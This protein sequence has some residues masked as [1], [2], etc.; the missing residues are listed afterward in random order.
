MKETSPPLDTLGRLGGKRDWSTADHFRETFTNG[1]FAE[2]FPIVEVHEAWIAMLVRSGV[3]PAARGATILQA[4]GKIDAAAVGEMI[5]S[6]DKRFPKPILQVERYLVD[7]IGM[8]ATD[9]ILE[10][11]LPP[12]LY[13]MKARKALLPLIASTL[14]LME[15][16]LEKSEAHRETVMPG[17]THLQH[18]QPMTFGHYLLG[19]YDALDR[20]LRQLEAA[21]ATT[22]RCDMGCGALAGVSVLVDRPFLAK[23]LGFDGIIEHSNDCVAA[24]DHAVDTV[25][26]M[27]NIALP[28]SRVAN[29][30]D[31]WSGFE[32]DMVEV[33]DE[34]AETSSL[35]PQ[36]KNPCV[37][38]EVRATI[39]VVSG[40]YNEIVC[41]MHNTSYGDT[42]EVQAACERITPTAGELVRILDFFEKAVR[43]L[44]VKAEK[45]RQHASRG[46]STVTELVAILYREAKLPPRVSH[47]IVSAVVRQVVAE[48]GTAL[49][50]RATAINEIA[51]K[52]I[53]QPLTITDD[54]IAAALD[55]VR[56]VEAHDSQGGVAPREVL[57]MVEARKG[58]L[59]AAG[60]RHDDRQARLEAAKLMRAE[61]IA[62]ICDRASTRSAA[63]TGA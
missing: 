7:Q 14:R 34:L 38:E 2:V 56:F 36:K 40:C 58:A 11:T 52:I 20:A 31:M 46:F 61:V 60:K 6:Y 45:M 3:V 13:R 57:R 35:M 49:D 29:E 63:P 25:L 51:R 24:T 55:P 30:L 47:A 44:S 26:A 15:T 42:I 53:E 4:L 39:A 1:A 17:Y 50:I 8:I 28:L 16:L 22:N 32:M 5:R 41:S 12:P 37:F 48:G 23:M 54:Q 18:A 62:G 43:T 21:Y 10:R 9:V 33:S 59:V 27:T 19:L